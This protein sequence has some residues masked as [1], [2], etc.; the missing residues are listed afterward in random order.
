MQFYTDI[1]LSRLTLDFTVNWLTL[2]LIRT[3]KCRLKLTNTRINDV[4]VHGKKYPQVRNI[5]LSR[6]KLSY[7]QIRVGLQS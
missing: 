2:T 1:N 6:K 5:H 3:N 7:T 4:L